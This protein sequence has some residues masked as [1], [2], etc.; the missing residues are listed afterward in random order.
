MSLETFKEVLSA[1]MSARKQ[2]LN[3]HNFIKDPIIRFHFFLRLTES[4]S[5]Y[6]KFKLVYLISKFIYLSISRRNGFSIPEGTMG[7]GVY[8]PHLG[9]IVVNSN[10]KIGDFS[11]I[12][13]D[14]VI[15]KTP[16]LGNEAPQIGQRVYIGPGVKIYGNCSVGNMVI[17]GAN[18]VVSGN[19]EGGSLVVGM[20]ARPM[21]P[22]SNCE[23]N[24]LE[25]KG[26]S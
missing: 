5:E 13:A 24:Y 20:P 2:E 12:N 10:A 11:T 26:G 17:I 16:W 15:G 22:L 4:L 8:L 9:T 14:V 19:I 21:R 7:K 23:W 25:R 1:D 6:P 3:I 18:A